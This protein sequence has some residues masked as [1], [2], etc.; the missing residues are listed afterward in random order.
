MF[1]SL[2]G[3]R[4]KGAKMMVKQL[5]LT[6]FLTVT[7][8]P[9]GITPPWYLVLYKP[10]FVDLVTSYNSLSN[11]RMQSPTLPSTSVGYN[12]LRQDIHGARTYCTMHGSAEITPSPCPWGT[13][14]NHRST[15]VIQSSGNKSIYRM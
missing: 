3:M 2:F 10:H 5:Y 4:T 11:L 7:V 15:Y 8:V 6:L 13:I 1:K 12:H 14:L 9:M